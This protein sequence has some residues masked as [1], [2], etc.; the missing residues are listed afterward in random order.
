MT[1]QDLSKY[2][3]TSKTSISNPMNQLRRENKIA[4]VKV[5]NTFLWHAVREQPK[6][7]VQK[8]AVKPVNPTTS[9]PHIRGYDD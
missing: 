1:I 4:Y 5:G 9:Y 8:P 3:A 2:F 7:V 6:T